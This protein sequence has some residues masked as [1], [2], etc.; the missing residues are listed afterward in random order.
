ML[1]LFLMNML[2]LYGVFLGV[3]FKYD[4]EIAQ[5]LDENRFSGEDVV[6]FKVPLAVPYYTDSK[7]YERVHGEFQ[8]EGEVFQLVKQ[9]LLGDTLYIVCVRDHQGKKINK[10]L[11]D[12]VKTFTDN[13]QDAK[14][15]NTKPVLPFSKDFLSTIVSL[16]PQTCGWEKSIVFSS[17]DN[18]LDHISLSLNGPPPRV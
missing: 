12:Y 5:S 3:Q 4:Q 1:A 15:Q 7:E 16:E 14:Q 2:G 18:R 10:A 9:K 8:I 13:P 17:V 11:A 6:T